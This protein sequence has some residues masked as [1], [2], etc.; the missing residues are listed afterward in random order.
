M[1]TLALMLRHP[2]PASV[3]R[4]V[5][6]RQQAVAALSARIAHTDVD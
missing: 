3:A 5:V 1:K 4:N 6:V 2:P